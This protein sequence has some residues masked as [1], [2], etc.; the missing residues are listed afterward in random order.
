MLSRVGCF[1]A[2]VEKLISSPFLTLHRLWDHS[3]IGS[4]WFLP[5]LLLKIQ[6]LGCWKVAPDK[7]RAAHQDGIHKGKL[8]GDGDKSFSVCQ[9]WPR[10]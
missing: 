1:K 4:E 3:D 5:G 7:S 2:S 6:P 9:R 8:V 10:R